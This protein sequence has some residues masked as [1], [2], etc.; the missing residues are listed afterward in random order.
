MPPNRIGG[1]MNQFQPDKTREPLS[2]LLR[3]KFQSLVRSV[4]YIIRL[5]W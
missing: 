5:Q 4:N 3:T 1:K 2:L